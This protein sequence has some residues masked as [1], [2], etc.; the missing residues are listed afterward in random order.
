ME[1]KIV[2]KQQ[3]DVIGL[4]MRTTFKEDLNHPEI[5]A[6][7]EKVMKEK[8]LEQ[9]P[10]KKD[11]NQYGI[12]ADMNEDD[13]TFAYIIAHEVTSMDDIPD[14]MIS[15]TIPEAEYAL[16]TVKGQFPKSIQDAFKYIYKEWF[17][18]SG[19]KHAG[20]PEFEY[21]DQRC[22]QEVPEM[23]IYIPVV[24]ID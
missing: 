5:P 7:W 20:T 16:F 17:P 10:N 4:E 18:N 19:Y 11:E 1:P 2:K 9:I 15:R 22:C 6:F 21:Y 12:C 23:D 3:F 14:G 24:K 13:K 8:M